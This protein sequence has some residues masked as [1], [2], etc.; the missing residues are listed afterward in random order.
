MK[1]DES[2]AK[3][4][5]PSNKFYPPH[6]DH[7]QSLLRSD[8]LKTKFP[9]DRH[10][11]KVIIVEAQAGQGKTTL[12]SQFLELSKTTSIWY[13]VGPEDSDPVLLLSFL[14]LNLNANLPG[15]QSQK[16]S[17]IL[18]AG[19]VGPL[20][21]TRCAN[22]LLHDLDNHLKEDLYLVFD[23]LH[24]IEFGTLTIRLLEHLIETSPPRVH[25][26]FMS[27]HPV[28]IKSKTVRNGVGVSYLNT[29]DLALNNHEIEDLYHTVLKQ[30]ISKHDAIQIRRITSGWIMGIILAS[31]P[32]SGRSRYWRDDSTAVLSTLPQTGHLLDYFQ[33][34]IFGAIPEKLHTPFLKLSFLQEIPV[35]LAAEIAEVD[36]IGQVL[37]SMTRE[38]YF[39]Y[40][41][42]DRRHVFRLH[43]FFQEF[44]QQRASD[45]FSAEDIAN[46]FRQEARYYLDR[47]LTEKALTCYKNAG[48]FRTMERILKD[49][50]ISLL[51]KNRTFTILTL[52][53]SLPEEILFQYNWLTLLAGLLRVDIAPQTTL[54]FFTRVRDRFVKTGEEAGEL[55]ALSKIIY[56]HF[57]ISGQYT[58]GS[59][60]LPRTRELLEKNKDTLPMPILVMA[61]RNL[62]AGYCFFNGEMD[63]ARFYIEK[64]SILATRHDIRNLIASTKFIQGYIE[65]FSGNRAKYLR[66][67]EICFSLF[68]DPLVSESNRLCLRLKDLCYLSMVGE[69][70]NFNIQQL[71]LQQSIDQTV[72]N[73]T[74]AAP[75]LFLWSASNSFS[76]GQPRHAL[77]LLET[78]LTTTSTAGTDHIH[79]QI[80]QWQAFGLAV[81]GYSDDAIDRIAQSKRLR[82]NAGGLFY[83][84]FHSIMAGAV[85]TR[86]KRYD[87]ALESLE[88]GLAIAQ[89]IPSTYLIICALL[90]L[91]HCRYEAAGAEAAVEFLGTGLGLMKVNGYTHFWSW[92]PAMMTKLLTLAVKCNIEKSFAQAL[93]RDRLHLGFSDDGD[94]VPLL[95]F[96]LMDRF[97][98]SLSGKILF[99]ARDLTYFQR[100][101]LGLLVTAKGQ[102]IAQDK[103]Q[104]ELWPERSPENARK[105][106]DT[107]LA[108]LRK[109]IAPHLPTSIKDY[110][111]IQKGILCLTNY[112]IDALQF[113]D[114]ATTGLS[115][116]KNGDWWQAHSA[117]HTAVSCWKDAMP[118]DTF[119]SEQILAF[120]D[121]LSHLL[122]EIGLTWANN[123]MQSGSYK[124]AISILERILQIDSLE[125]SLTILLYKL[126]LLNNNYLKAREL[127]ERY[128]KALIKALYTETEADSF[129]DKI[130]RSVKS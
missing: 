55:I 86:V 29:K 33:D 58:R 119:H 53:R 126:H 78:A 22:F 69:H 52:L 36:N 123:L 25:F 44:L 3:Y 31:H 34:E 41:L 130:V 102:R 110:L 14:L 97:E 71:A 98:V 28:E 103:I 24:L 76:L 48:D 45:Q 68:N 115:H 57:V 89:T 70:Q 72:V 114:K 127:L 6:I 47:N 40:S 107:L 7:S 8:L 106:F 81:T 64:A 100:E 10:N 9:D 1:Q 75:C 37:S 105:S 112:E 101:M 2:F 95:K 67:A 27:R 46:I 118:E 116:C 19:C 84:A 60:I 87:Q 74:V 122:I 88:R 99:R 129:I 96:S 50:G 124:E 15:F 82:D 85:Y 111:F 51:A 43:H 54:P 79:S 91:S 42:D 77:E 23:D 20:D 61:A 26:I 121:R 17:N 38:N 11:K 62:A 73:Q 56:Y 63:K 5:V 66:E 104:L 16:L 18:N 32:M 117:F 90:N 108:R 113:F 21:L 93:A 30:E 39:L 12:V 59:E 83:L 49:Q 128:R 35:D 94:P 120:N 109:L 80:L 125:E 13:Q 92:E 4:A 65:L